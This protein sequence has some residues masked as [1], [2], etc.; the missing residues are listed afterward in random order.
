MSNAPNTKKEIKAVTTSLTSATSNLIKWGRLTGR[1]KPITNSKES[2][3]EMV[4]VEP[5]GNINVAVDS[6]DRSRFEEA[7]AIQYLKEEMRNQKMAMAKLTVQI[8]KLVDQK[9]QR[10]KQ[11]QSQQQSKRS[12]VPSVDHRD[13]VNI[14]VQREGLICVGRRFK[15]E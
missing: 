13:K 1:M 14:M 10:E 15:T 11:Q 5:A 7:G 12:N 3:T 2:Q 9:Y 8:D 6:P 4:D